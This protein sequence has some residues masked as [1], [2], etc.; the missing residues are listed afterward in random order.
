M[1]ERKESNRQFGR[2]TVAAV[3]PV[4]AV[5]LLA[6]LLLGATLDSAHAVQVEPSDSGPVAVTATLDVDA[7]SGFYLQVTGT[8][9]LELPRDWLAEREFDSL[10]DGETVS[11]QDLSLLLS[12]LGL[13]Q[14]SE[15]MALEPATRSAET[16]WKVPR[17]TLVGTTTLSSLDQDASVLG[18]FGVSPS[19]S[20]LDLYIDLTSV[21]TWTQRIVAIEAKGLAIDTYDPT[22]RH[23]IRR[24]RRS[25]HDV[26]ETSPEYHISASIPPTLIAQA[27][28]EERASADQVSVTNKIHLQGAGTGYPQ[29]TCGM[30]IQVPGDWPELHQLWAH[31][32]REPEYQQALQFLVESVILAPVDYQFFGHRIAE[33]LLEPPSLTVQGNTATIAFSTT[34][35]LYDFWDVTVP[36]CLV[37][38]GGTLPSFPSVG[39]M[40]LDIAASQVSTQTSW[41][42][43]LELEGIELVTASPRPMADDGK[44]HL[45]WAGSGASSPGE[46]KIVARPDLG[47]RIRF[48]LSHRYLIHVERLVNLFAANVVLLFVFW[49]LPRRM[50]T[51]HD[52]EVW[53]RVRKL[54]VA[55]L[56]ILVLVPGAGFLALLLLLQTSI[57]PLIVSCFFFVMAALFFWRARREMHRKGVLR[58]FVGL[59][60]GL[61]VLTL[62]LWIEIRSGPAA[63]SGPA[64][65]VALLAL[66]LLLIPAW[67]ASRYALVAIV[68]SGIALGP[69]DEFRR[70]AQERNFDLDKWYRRLSAFMVLFIAV[71]LLQ[72]LAYQYAES[73]NWHLSLDAMTTDW[74]IRQW[75]T[76]LATYPL[77]LWYQLED[78]L[79]YI[80]LAGLAGVLLVLGK[81]GRGSFFSE[82]AGWGL[83]SARLLFAAFVVGTSGWYV[84]FGLPLAFLMA[85]FL[86]RWV[87]QMRCR[88]VVDQ[89]D[90]LNPD[91]ADGE[92][93]VA[94]AHHRELLQR[95]EAIE[96]LQYRTKLLH[97]EYRAGKVDDKAYATQHDKLSAEIERLRRG[98]APAGSPSGFFSPHGDEIPV[99]RGLWHL[100]TGFL[101][102]PEPKKPEPLAA[103]VCLPD[104][105]TPGQLGLALGPASSP[106]ANGLLALRIGAIA[107]ILPI[108]F[109]V[110]VL[111]TERGIR[112]LSPDAYF[113]VLSLT[114]G[115]LSEVAFWLVA[116]FVLGCVYPYLLGSNGF[117]KGTALAAVYVVAVS[118]D[119]LVN[120]WLGETWSSTWS[121]RALQ[122]FLFL[123]VVGVA[124]DWY[125]LRKRR[126]Y[127]RH[128]IDFYQLRDV[129]NLVAYLS[130]LALALFAISQQLL[131]GE[132]QQSITQ[133]LKSLP[134]AIPPF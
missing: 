39:D 95:A 111:L 89:V 56:W 94:F 122:L 123:V 21:P 131:S 60:I 92:Q 32:P 48:A 67:L 79:P 14:V 42:V 133:I 86:S 96:V 36:G 73:G 9:T 108:G 130:P 99:V 23:T 20:V 66:P 44:G 81:S 26:G 6:L 124:M 80:A 132:A 118:F 90:S 47:T 113:G 77:N 29:L 91:L 54:R 116:A 41:I 109:Y 83:R 75:Q 125:T 63:D 30:V 119:V 72:Y 120:R 12:D 103:P 115:L 57:E 68:E 117:L 112:F 19:D 114:R 129:K 71:M 58:V 93:P 28:L 1:N 16:G 25:T 127:W 49:A 15:A 11:A 87:L 55:V 128:L 43:D 3:V 69:I 121:T 104:R 65:I 105:V 22:Y 51:D 31:S 38:V 35:P 37:A 59:L 13:A 7:A 52:Q 34:L 10:L 33:D 18:V 2:R 101:S 102:K 88:E 76:V 53:L 4:L 107:S 70:I 40:T 74:E 82:G 5:L 97:D 24:S 98:D 100:V 84:G 110:Y 27:F 17:V 64:A 46:I 62:S 85:L 126:L 50:Q 134:Q 8:L 45:Q 106:W 78:F 61:A